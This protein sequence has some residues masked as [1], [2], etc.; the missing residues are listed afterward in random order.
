MSSSGQRSNS[1]H[2][3]SRLHAGQMTRESPASGA[4]THERE[5]TEGA[6]RILATAPGTTSKPHHALKVTT[7]TLHSAPHLYEFWGAYSASE[8]DAITAAAISFLKRTS[9]R[10]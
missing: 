7:S 10:S 3:K 4:T 2:L 6:R 9:I 8:N 5:G 1:A